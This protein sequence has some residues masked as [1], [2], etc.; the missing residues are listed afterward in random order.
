MKQDVKLFIENAVPNEI[1]RL[2]N[3]KHAY[4]FQ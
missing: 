3:R 2:T 1:K 4:E